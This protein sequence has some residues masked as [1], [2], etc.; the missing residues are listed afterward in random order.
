M[1]F[2]IFFYYCNILEIITEE[3]RK[4][5]DTIQKQ[6]VSKNISNERSQDPSQYRQNK[7]SRYKKIIELQNKV[8]TFQENFTKKINKL[9]N[10][11]TTKKEYIFEDNE[12]INNEREYLLETIKLYIYKTIDNI[13]FLQ[14]ERIL[15]YNNLKQDINDNNNSNKIKDTNTINKLQI[16]SSKDNKPI[17]ESLKVYTI[18]SK[19][20]VYEPI[21]PHMKDYIRHIDPTIVNE[22]KEKTNTINKQE[23][24]MTKK[25]GG[26]GTQLPACPTHGDSHPIGKCP[27][28]LHGRGGPSRGAQ[29][30][31][32]PINYTVTLATDRKQIFK[33]INPYMFDLDEWARIQQN[34]GVLPTPEKVAS[35]LKQKEFEYQRSIAIENGEIPSD[36]QIETTQDEYDRENREIQRARDWDEFKDYVPRGSGNLSRK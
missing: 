11:N 31:P 21:P 32:D 3:Q 14:K 9:L 23:Y 7:I 17:D 25:I 22:N 20:Q 36:L 24:I 16:I 15:L 10:D 35:H 6:W 2:N 12:I 13:E 29:G 34:A 8:N 1:Y 19:E 30:L 18:S 5:W 28:I 27:G 26:R 4:Y 33:D